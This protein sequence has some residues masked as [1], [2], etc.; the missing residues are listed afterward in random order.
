MKN[1]LSISEKA[2]KNFTRCLTEAMTVIGCPLMYEDAIRELNRYLAGECSD[3]EGCHSLAKFALTLLRDEID[4]CMAR[5]AKA[6][7]RAGRKPKKKEEENVCQDA[8]VP[9]MKPIELNQSDNNPGEKQIGE[10]NINDTFKPGGQGL[11]IGLREQ[12]ECGPAEPTDQDKPFDE[13]YSDV[14]TVVSS[15]QSN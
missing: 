14:K 8:S 10:E 7:A 6:R 13:N 2:Y 5:S 11:D 15:G 3:F 9:P 12:C 1:R 4:R